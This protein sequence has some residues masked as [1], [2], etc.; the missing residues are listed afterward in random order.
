[1]EYMINSELI[2]KQRNER[3]WSQDHLASVSG[4]SLRTIQR[5]EKEGKCSL[6][7]KKALASVFEIDANDLDFVDYSSQIMVA[8]KGRRYGLLG[9]G[10][11]LFCSYSAITYSVINGSMLLGE[12]G[13]Y[14]GVVGALTGITCGLIGY[15]SKQNNLTST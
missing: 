15:F 3:T 8:N 7:S 2:K 6:D 1:M 4:L 10:I 14:Y 12:A 11:G 9:A 13:G 5:I